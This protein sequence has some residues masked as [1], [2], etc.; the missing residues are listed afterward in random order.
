MPVL[1]D[2]LY[3]N[4]LFRIWILPI[5]EKK[6]RIRF[7][8]LKKCGS[9]SA[10][11]HLGG[12]TECNEICLY[13][14]MVA[15]PP[16]SFRIQIQPTWTKSGSGSLSLR[17]A[18]LTPKHHIYEVL[19]NVRKYACTVRWSL[20][21]PPGRRST[22]RAGVDPGGVEGGPCNSNPSKQVL[23]PEIY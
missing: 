3:T 8:T 16:H 9:E 21:H 15:K 17:S 7:P 23:L 11:P 20:Y 2:S 4:A 22:R 12:T 5:W 6:M 14:K 18:D 1:W 19:V 10:T 13:C